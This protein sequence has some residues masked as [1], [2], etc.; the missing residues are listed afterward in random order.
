MS[1]QPQKHGHQHLEDGPDPIPGLG[2]RLPVARA[3]STGFTIEP[4]TDYSFAILRGEFYGSVEGVADKLVF[5]NTPT[6]PGDSGCFFSETVR[7]GIMCDAGLG[8]DGQTAPYCKIG[9]DAAVYFVDPAVGTTTL[10]LHQGSPKW[11]TFYNSP[12]LNVLQH[13]MIDPE[14]N[15]TLRISGEF[16]WG[17]SYTNPEIQSVSDLILPVIWHDG[18]DPITA[19]QSWF[20]MTRLT[21]MS[22]ELEI[23]PEE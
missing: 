7:R 2:G 8:A 12:V 16:I 11:P 19:G 1:D 21:P 9:F 15:H 17:G 10:F 5:G 20:T 18:D 23:E 13:R 3:T 14:G 22:D 6:G 4:G